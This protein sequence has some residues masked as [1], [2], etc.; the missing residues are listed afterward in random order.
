MNDISATTFSVAEKRRNGDPCVMTDLAP[1]HGHLAHTLRQAKTQH[2]VDTLIEERAPHISAWAIWPV[3]RPMLYS[4]LSY[5]RARTMADTIAPLRGAAAL[6]HISALLNVRLDIVGL[7][8]LPRTGRAVA[9]ANHPTG[10]TDGIA[11]RDALS[12]TRPDICFYANAD[13][14]RV[15]PGFGDVLIPVEWEAHKRTRE[16]TR[17]TLIETQKAMQEERLLTIFPAGRLARRID[18][19]L[20]DPTWMASAVSVARKHG[21]P[22]VPIYMAGPWS[23]WFHTFD[24]FSK[25]LRDITLFHELLNKTGGLYQIVIAP[26]VPMAALEGDPQAVTDRLKRFVEHDLRLDHGAVFG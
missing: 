21:A 10:I 23:F 24:R 4:L 19:V 26:P 11:L 17:V 20:Q 16:R 5:Q 9:V 18:E 1:S 25:E 15:C 12:P 6:D 8:N 14:H 22:I 7:E 13:A 2:V 3:L